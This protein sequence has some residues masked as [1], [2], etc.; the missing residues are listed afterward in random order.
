MQFPEKYR[1][2][3]QP[4]DIG[5]G[6][7]FTVPIK[8]SAFKSILIVIATN[9]MGWEHASIS[10]YKQNRCPSWEEMCAVKQLFWTDEETVVQYHPPKAEYVNNH[11]YCLHLWKP[12]KGEIILPPSILIGIK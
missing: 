6:G 10:V 3:A 1:N 7:L 12:I 4:S 5:K 2:Q 8:N 11:P 9:G